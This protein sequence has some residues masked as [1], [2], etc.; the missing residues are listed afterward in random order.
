MGLWRVSLS[1]LVLEPSGFLERLGERK[2]MGSMFSELS[3]S[4]V[5]A[6]RLMGEEMDAVEDVLLIV[7]RL[8]MWDWDWIVGVGGRLRMEAYHSDDS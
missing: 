8:T 7:E 6:L 1:L 2:M 3:S 5:W 4:K